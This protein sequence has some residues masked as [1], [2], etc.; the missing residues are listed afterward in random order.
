MEKWLDEGRAVLRFEQV[1]GTHNT[2]NHI[3]PFLEIYFIA[4]GELA[5][6]VNGRTWTAVAGDIVVIPPLAIRSLS[7]PER[8][9]MAVCRTSYIFRRGLI[10]DDDFTSRRTTVVFKPSRPLRAYL[11]EI[12]FYSK[13]SVHGVDERRDREIIIRTRAALHLIL[14]EFIIACPVVATVGTDS[15]LAQILIYLSFH[16]TEQVTLD[17]VAEALDLSPKYVSN[18]FA[19]IPGVSFRSFI[20]S[21]RI[22]EAKARLESTSD[23]VLTI[24]HLCGFHNESSFHRI[25]RD[26]TGVTP[27]EYREGKRG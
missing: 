16:Y 17:T 24:G 14:S 10:E 19:Q 4:E 9:K 23:P 22:D 8:V 3:N 15:T 12:D 27:T 11:S 1:D 13:Q 6:T 5:V 20:N 25:F 7:T 26:H 21:L 2:D 18:C